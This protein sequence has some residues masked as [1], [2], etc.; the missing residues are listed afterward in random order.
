[1]KVRVDA[2]IAPDLL[3]LFLDRNDGKLGPSVQEWKGTCENGAPI[4]DDDPT[5]PRCGGTY[6]PPGIVLEGVTM[7][8]VAEMLSLPQS[9]GLLGTI[10]TD[11]TGLKG[12][13]NLKL[14]YPFPPAGAPQ[15]V[16]APSLFSAVR[17][18]WGLKIERA[19]GPFKIVTIDSAEHPTEN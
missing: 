5:L 3:G 12:R 8:N 4:E 13:F 2:E 7:F 18:Q 10:V 6:R 19:A 15:P 1:M 14:D 17:E 11:H 16:A 9:R